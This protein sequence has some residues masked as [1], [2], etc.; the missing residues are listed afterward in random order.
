MLR[1]VLLKA[2]IPKLLADGQFEK[3]EAKN[4]PIAAA[5]IAIL[6]FSVGDLI[7]KPVTLKPAST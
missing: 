1:R 4:P 3:S 6:E 7:Y 5:R 2:Y